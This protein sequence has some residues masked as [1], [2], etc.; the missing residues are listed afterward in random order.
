M[1]ILLK[2]VLQEIVSIMFVDIK[3]EQANFFLQ[4]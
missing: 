2:D 3:L 4:K 1:M